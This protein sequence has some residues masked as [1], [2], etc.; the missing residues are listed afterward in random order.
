MAKVEFSVP[1]NLRLSDTGVWGSGLKSPGMKQDGPEEA[2]PAASASTETSM[3]P[4]APEA[5]AASMDVLMN[6]TG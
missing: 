3:E 4:G 6:T 1:Q 5:S 2:A